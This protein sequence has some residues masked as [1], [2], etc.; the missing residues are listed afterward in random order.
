[1]ALRE[2]YEKQGAF[3]FRWRSYIPLLILPFA[4]IVFRDPAYLHPLFA[5][6]LDTF[7]EL[8]AILVSTMGFVIRILVAG[9][10]PAGT[11]GRNTLTQV[12]NVLNTK[13]MYSIVRNPLYLGNF[14]IILGILL[15]TQVWWFV[16][17]ASLA[18]WIYYER[19]IFTEEEFLRKKFGEAFTSW[20]EKT[21][22]FIPNFSLWEKADL[23]FSWK[24][25]LR[26]EYSGLFGMAAAFT[27]LGIA[28]D[29]LVEHEPIDLFWIVFLVV[30]FALYVTFRFLKKKTNI[31]DVEGRL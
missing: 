4:I 8:F 16:L 2:I 3:L 28:S 26:K 13:G 25:V 29:F 24:I 17:W 11:S 9:H 1:M 7:W 5:S 20:A 14:L 6:P 19:I 12:A 22:M 18:F 31:L 15:F 21:P 10:V 30:S 23:P 27:A